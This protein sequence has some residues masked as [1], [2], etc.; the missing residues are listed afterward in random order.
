M[1]VVTSGSFILGERVRKLELELESSLG[2][3][4]VV[5]VGSGTEALVL[6]LRGLDLPVSSKVVT[7]PN[8]GGYATTAIVLA[9][10]RPHYVDCLPDGGMSPEGL[11]QTLE[12]DPDVKAV[13]VT[14]LYG[15][16]GKV[17]E[18][19]HICQKFSVSLIE[20]C[21][22]SI[23]ARNEV[24]QA[25]TF[26]DVA[27]FSF[28]PT[29]NLGALGDAGAISTKKEALAKRIRN[30]R[31]Y[32]WSE[33]YKIDIL[34]GTNSRMDE[35]QAAVL[36]SRLP[37]LE[38]TNSIRQQIWKRYAASLAESSWEIIGN[39][40]S[41]FVAH[42]G[43]LVCPPG[44]RD[45][46]IDFLNNSGIA[47]AVHYPILDYDQEAWRAFLDTRCPTAEDLVRRILTIPLFPE[48][49]EIEVDR[50]QTA[51]RELEM[52]LT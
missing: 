39:S 14:H 1:A 35:V 28:Y 47:V 48:M 24:G 6:A 29:K 32:G 2:L 25:G 31:Q 26:G 27:T 38:N 18:I 51:L 10:L 49:T 42:L 3:Q 13:V 17:Q 20:D 4:N 36:I 44:K 11:E 46:T 43:I 15:L 30:L 16:M 8:S 37:S 41:E 33:R 50:V 21:A 12:M 23:G 7:T 52:K 19:S 34:N 40:T 9:G 45:A 5:A 22:Q